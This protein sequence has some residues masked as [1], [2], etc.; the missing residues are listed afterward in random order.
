M[1]KAAEA[2]LKRQLKK[3]MDI[4]IKY[5]DSDAR[6]LSEPFMKLPSRRKLPDYYEV[7][8]RPIDIKKI[9]TKIDENRYSSLDDLQSDFNL[10]CKNAQR[11]NEE[12]SLIHEDSIVLESV[13]ANAMERVASL[14]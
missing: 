6:I 12:S 11:Y 7:I 9:L 4:V 14:D 1:D 2:K 13:F 8:K 5:A 3:I 10:L